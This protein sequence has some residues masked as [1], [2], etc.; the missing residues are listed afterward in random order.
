MA[1]PSVFFSYSHADEGMRDQLEK[2]LAIL[3]RQGTIE[4]WHDRHIQPGEDFAQAIDAHINHDQIILLLVSPD[5]I[6]S[7]YCYDIEMQRA[8]E[9][10]ATGD[11]IVIPVILRACDWHSTPF[12]RLQAVP[13]DGKPIKQWPDIDEAMLQVA[14]AVRRAAERWQAPQ[15]DARLAG[16]VSRANA[17]RV[18]MEPRSSNMRLAKSFTQ[19]DKDRFKDE[20][21]EYIAKF[22][23]NSLAELTA[24]NPGYEG[25]FKRVD[26]NRFFAT[27]YHN[28]R[29]VARATY[30]TGGGL[31]GTGINYT[32][33]ES[34]SSN[35]TQ[36]TL[37]IEADD[38]SIF[39]R[40]TMALGDRD[41]KLSQE[42]AAEHMWELL[43]APLQQSTRF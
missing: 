1:A 39:L 2:Q 22:I 16:H 28:G 34:T 32:Q 21:F 37:S 17:S 12:G 19:R 31:F 8:M 13:R 26:A 30:F 5:F 14:M 24:R 3:K 6:A 42:G 27:I 9:R 40:S 25:A 38:H 23:E 33:G 29:D 10:H 41:K 18:P 35:S 7:D 15:A 36:E 20:T 11:A 4:T 43:I